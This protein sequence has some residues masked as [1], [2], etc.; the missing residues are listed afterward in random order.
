MVDTDTNLWALPAGIHHAGSHAD[1]TLSW[2]SK[3][4][5]VVAGMFDRLTVDGINER[6]LTV[7]GLYLTEADY[8]VREQQRPGLSLAVAVQYL[9]DNFATVAEAV[10]WLESS[11]VQI[12]P[13]LIGKEKAPG[14]AHVSLADVTGDSAIVEFLDGKTVIHH[15]P[16]FTIMTNSPEFDK[17]LEHLKGF[18]P[19]EDLQPLPGS[20]VSP[21]RFVRASY[22]ADRLP[23][24]AD[25]R[26]A[27]ANV[28]SVVRNASV[29]YGVNDP[30]HPNIAATRWR[31]L[32][33]LTHRRYFFDSTTA[34]N[35]LW[36]DLDDL[37]L[38]EGAPV[39]KLDLLSSVDRVGNQSSEFV[40]GETFPAA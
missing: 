32:A 23:E 36:V 16:E 18:Q 33:D 11:H 26:T 34:P 20:S 14:T 12:I 1:N 15:S 2:T 37:D 24:T 6:A 31:V 21:D 7:N 30:E 9:L 25:A 13:V 27:I 4:G 35:L 40:A 19:F 3:Y 8:G 39:L 5:S 38:S 10:E 29:P 28:L 17:Q 22:Y